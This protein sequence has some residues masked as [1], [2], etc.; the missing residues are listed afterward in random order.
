MGRHGRKVVILHPL[1][2]LSDY[3]NH[4]IDQVLRFFKESTSYFQQYKNNSFADHSLKLLW[5]SLLIFLWLNFEFY[6]FFCFN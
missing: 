1:L 2:F 4:S 6:V 3:L 5:W